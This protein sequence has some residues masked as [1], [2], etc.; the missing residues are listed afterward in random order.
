MN[1]PTE[2]E[3]KEWRDSRVAKWFFDTI[4]QH[5]RMQM[6]EQQV[7]RLQ[8]RGVGEVAMQA[9]ERSGY[10]AGVMSVESVD[11]TQLCESGQ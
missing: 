7:M 2:E 10:V 1:R 9:A 4:E 11:Y 5:L 3:F 8:G 6:L